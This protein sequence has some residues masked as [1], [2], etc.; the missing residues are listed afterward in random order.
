MDNKNKSV[1]DV[2]YVLRDAFHFEELSQ[3]R[4]RQIITSRWKYN[5]AQNPFDPD[6]T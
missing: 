2:F 3:N 4:L 6:L 5:T 1:D